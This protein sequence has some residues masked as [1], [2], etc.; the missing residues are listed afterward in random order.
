MLSSPF[1]TGGPAVPAFEL[2]VAV[3]VNARFAVTVN[4]AFYN[5]GVVFGLVLGEIESGY[6]RRSPIWLEQTVVAT[7]E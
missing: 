7:A 2:A 6:R 4:S 1:Y 5:A 3:K